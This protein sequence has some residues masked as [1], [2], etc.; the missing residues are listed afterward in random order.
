M[1]LGGGVVPVT[2]TTVTFRT[3]LT[4][5]DTGLPEDAK[6]AITLRL[7]EPKLK[8]GDAIKEHTL[9]GGTI[10]HDGAAESGK[11]HADYL[12]TVTGLWH[13]EWLVVGESVDQG[14][15]D[16]ES[17]RPEG[18]TPDLTDLKVLVPRARRKVEGPWGNP[19]GKPPL[20]ESVL[21]NMIGDAVGE[22]IMLSGS[23][24]HHELKVK[25]RD[26]LGGFPTD[27]QTDTPLTE[28]ESAIICAQVALNYY[29]YLFR[30]MKVSESVKNEGTEWSFEISANAIRNYYESL[31][32][33]RDRAIEGLRVNIPVLDRFA[34]NI[35]VR[36]QA[37]VAVLEWWAGAYD[38][39]AGGGL[40]GGQEA[41]AIPWFPSP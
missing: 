14:D 11:Y 28:W 24:F 22:I 16:M 23:F 2:G 25:Q 39:N 34:S 10:K 40:P 12:P 33:E 15:L 19:N 38:S 17:K 35:R 26:P 41:S 3:A 9:E 31:V 6:G 4:N 27:W 36:D 37:T 20:T 18:G 7:V 21:Y 1:G 32:K 5:P 8:D 30:N 29:Q 13:W